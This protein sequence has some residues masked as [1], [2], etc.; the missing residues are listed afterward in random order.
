VYFSSVAAIGQPRAGEVLSD[1]LACRPDT[2]YGRVKRECE[3]MLLQAHATHGLAV[4]I[5]RPTAVYGPGEVNWWLPLFRAVHTGRVPFFGDGENLIG[6][7]YIDNLVDAALLAGRADDAAGRTYVIAD[8]RPYRSRELIDAVAA[9]CGVA[10]PRRHVPRR[11]AV[12]V[13]SFLDDLGRLDL[14]TPIVPFLATVARLWLTHSPCDIERARR[15]LGYRPRVGLSAGVG[16]AAA[17]YRD[18]G[19]LGA[20]VQ[21]FDGALDAPALPRRIE[22][23]VQRTTRVS[24]E[25]A[26]LAWRLFALT[27]RLPP[28]LVRRARRRRQVARLRRQGARA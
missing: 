13:A 15:E 20:P 19:L 5:L 21:W 18:N 4:V 26:D 9:A 7:C 22:T 14:V 17:W 23:R 2:P 24:V 6:L 3:T 25:S 28:R 12:P 8:E 1:E 16:T 10:A 27:W 11:L